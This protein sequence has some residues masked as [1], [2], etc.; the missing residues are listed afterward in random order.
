MN[1]SYSYTRQA[2]GDIEID[3]IGNCN[4]VAYNDNADEFYLRI[5]TEDGWSTIIDAGPV[6]PD[7]E[8]KYFAMF[9]KKLE[10]NEKKI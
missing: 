1:F 10:F 7:L 4:I 2:T 9:Y 3:D 8:P 6:T 5:T